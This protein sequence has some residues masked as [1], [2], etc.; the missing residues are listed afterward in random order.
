[1]KTYAEILLTAIKRVRAHRRDLSGLC[2]MFSAPF[3]Y[4]LG[5]KRIRSPV[6]QLDVNDKETLRSF[7]YGFFKTHFF[8]KNS[9]R[10]LSGKSRFLVVVDVGAN[11]GDFTLGMANVAEKIVAVE[12]GKENFRALEANLEINNVCNVVPV[13]A[14]AN[15]KEEDLFLQG[16]A[17]DM[18]VADEKRGQPVKGM[19]LDQILQTYGI[20]TVDVLKVD[21]QGHEMSVLLGMHQL[22]LKKAVKLLIIEAHLKRGVRIEDVVQFMDGYG[23]QLAHSDDYLFDQPHL[24]FV[25][26][27][28]SVQSSGFV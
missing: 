8:Y 1:M 4:F 2:F 26:D 22:L 3:L 18:F 14:A 13:N 25:P 20:G 6:G 23:Y 5:V 9:L 17:S 16:N 10:T 19:P 27:L 24:Y 11:I 12:P 28:A 15:E 7:A 21:V